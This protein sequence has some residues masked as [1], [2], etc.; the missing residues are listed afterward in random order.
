[1][2]PNQRMHLPVLQVPGLRAVADPHQLLVCSMHAQAQHYPHLG[3]TTTSGGAGSFIRPSS[4]PC[5]SHTAL[6]VEIWLDGSA[7]RAPRL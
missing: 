3:Q 5:C 4:L 6:E 7:N 1:M 2:Q